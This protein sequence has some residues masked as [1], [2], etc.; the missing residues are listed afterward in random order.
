MSVAAAYAVEHRGEIDLTTV[1]PTERGAKLNW[2][3]TACGVLLPDSMTDDLIEKI[4]RKLST[5][6]KAVCIQVTIER[7]P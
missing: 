1:Y 7:T 6:Q 4:W 5:D 3:V 2:L